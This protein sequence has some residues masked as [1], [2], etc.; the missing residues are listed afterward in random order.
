MKNSQ[1]GQKCSENDF[2]NLLFF[3]QNSPKQGGGGK[4]DFGK[5]QKKVVF[6]KGGSPQ[7]DP[8][9]QDLVA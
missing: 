3:F 5:V 9:Y 7:N 8:F 2:Q 6:L 4:P 1:N